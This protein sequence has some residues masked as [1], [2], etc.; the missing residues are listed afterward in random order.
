M[1]TRKIY[2]ESYDAFN[3]MVEKIEGVKSFQLKENSIDRDVNG[4]LFL[5]LELASK[6]MLQV[7]LDHPLHIAY[8]NRIKP[9]LEHKLS[10]DCE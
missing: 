9:I 2:Q 7:Y 3:E 4:D 8:A 10:L 5:T 1:Y 6:D